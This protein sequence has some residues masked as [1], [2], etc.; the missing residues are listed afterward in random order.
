MGIAPL[1]YFLRCLQAIL[2]FNNRRSCYGFQG[3]VFQLQE[4]DAFLRQGVATF[5]KSHHL[6]LRLQLKIDPLVIAGI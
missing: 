3:G 5:Q 2:I 6:Q 1:R 4:K